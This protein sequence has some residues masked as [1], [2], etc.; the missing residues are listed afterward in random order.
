M[1]GGW[2]CFWEGGAEGGEAGGGHMACAKESGL[3]PQP[4][5]WQRVSVGARHGQICLSEQSLSEASGHRGQLEAE[6]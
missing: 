6:T 4:V 5:G 3:H 1:G 2:L